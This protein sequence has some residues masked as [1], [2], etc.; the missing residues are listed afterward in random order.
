M[1]IVACENIEWLVNKLNEMGV[2]YK[3]TLLVDSTYEFDLMPSTRVDDLLVLASHCG[4]FE[5]EVD[6]RTLTLLS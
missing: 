3:L 6:T 2:S 1:K 5:Y 4:P